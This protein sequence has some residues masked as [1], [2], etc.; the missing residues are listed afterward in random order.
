M[1]CNK[2]L[3]SPIWLSDHFAAAAF[4]IFSSDDLLPNCSR[5][6]TVADAAEDADD[7]SMLHVV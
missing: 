2:E 4:L 6:S 5:D 7:D 3:L 1:K